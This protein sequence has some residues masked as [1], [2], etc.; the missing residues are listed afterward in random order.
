MLLPYENLLAQMERN[1]QRYRERHQD[2]LLAEGRAKRA[3]ETAEQKEARRAA[4]RAKYAADREI[5]GI[6]RRAWE[7]AHPD[8]VLALKAK[9]AAVVTPRTPVSG[10]GITPTS[11]TVVPICASIPPP[12]K[13]TSD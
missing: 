5:H 7:M 1:R 10:L 2:R 3:A 11:R 8:K 4:R 9:R 6:K 12:R 13:A